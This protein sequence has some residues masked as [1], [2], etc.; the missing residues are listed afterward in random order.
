MT[1]NPKKLED[2]KDPTPDP[3]R[4]QTLNTPLNWLLAFGAIVLYNVAGLDQTAL[5]AIFDPKSPV[6]TQVLNSLIPTSI[7]GAIRGVE[8]FVR[9]AMLLTITRLMGPAAWDVVSP[10]LTR[11]G[12]LAVRFAGNFSRAARERPGNQ[13]DSD[14]P[15]KS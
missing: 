3:G 2:P 11:V 7:V 12:N 10:V 9:A 6:V 8:A 15:N 13:N 14:S 5:D 1:D 4:R